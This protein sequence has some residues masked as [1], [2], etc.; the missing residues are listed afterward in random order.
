[1]F[2]K[3]NFGFISYLL[4][5]FYIPHPSHPH[6]YHPENIWW[7][8]SL[9]IISTVYCTSYDVVLGH[10]VAC[11]S[12]NVTGSTVQCIIFNTVAHAGSCERST[13]MPWFR[14]RWQTSVY[15]D[16]YILKSLCPFNAEAS[17]YIVTIAGP[18]RVRWCNIIFHYKHKII[19]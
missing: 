12:L 7:K 9:Q 14:T 4:H 8:C 11:E 3:Q 2:S 1:M 5:A 13:V 6:F 19:A 17:C 15:I 16:F 18:V 10:R